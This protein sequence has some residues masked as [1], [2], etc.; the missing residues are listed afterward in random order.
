MAKVV[1]DPTTQEWCIMIPMQE[2]LDTRA[3]G[4]WWGN[5][6]EVFHVD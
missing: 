2:P 5:V 6:E 1:E 4:E 3:E